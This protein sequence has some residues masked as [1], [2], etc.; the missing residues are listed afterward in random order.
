[1]NFPRLLYTHKVYFAMKSLPE[2][3]QSIWKSKKSFSLNTTLAALEA[4]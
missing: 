2:A 1:M 3:F 4:E